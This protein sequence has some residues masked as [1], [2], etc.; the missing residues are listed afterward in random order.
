MARSPRDAGAAVAGL[1]VISWENCKM[2]P[3]VLATPFDCNRIN[4][5]K[6]LKSKVGV[7]NIRRISAKANIVCFMFLGFSKRDASL[8]CHVLFL[9]IISVIY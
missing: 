9:N 6:S 4:A 8:Q 5:L 3:I 2:S 1:I 7:Q